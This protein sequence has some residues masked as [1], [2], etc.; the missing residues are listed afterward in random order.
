MEIDDVFLNHLNEFINSREQIYFTNQTKIC[1]FVVERIY[2]R[3][4]NNYYFGGVKIDFNENII[5]DGN[6]RFIA[7]SLAG[8]EFEKIPT[9]KN[10]CDT[11]PYKEFKN[12]TVD[13]TNDWDLNNPKTKK[14]CDDKFLEDETDEKKYKRH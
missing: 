2:K 14:Y 4:L 8:C 11:P 12:I 9:I 10:F 5:I 6:H 13:I 3:V 1:Y 7:Y